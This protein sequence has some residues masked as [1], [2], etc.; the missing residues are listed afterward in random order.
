[1]CSFY[2]IALCSPAFSVSAKYMG[3]IDEETQLEATT[4][5]RNVL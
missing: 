2:S 4:D 1:M 5:G 3:D